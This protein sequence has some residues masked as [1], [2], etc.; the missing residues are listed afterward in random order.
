MRRLF[1][2]CLFLVGPWCWFAMQGSSAP[3]WSSP[4]PSSPPSSSPSKWPSQANAELTLTILNRTIKEG[5]QPHPNIS[6]DSD[7]VRNSSSSSIPYYYTDPLADAAPP[8]INVD[9][10]PVP[11]QVMEQYRKW[12]SVEALRSNP[13][14]E[15]RKF[16]IGFYACPIQAGNRIHHFLN[17]MLWAILTNRTL[18][19]QYWDSPTCMRWSRE[20]MV[21]RSMNREHEC[22]QILSRADWI[23]SYEEWSQTL[24]LDEP[25]EIPYHANHPKF[26]TI[27]RYTWHEGDEKLFGA[28]NRTKYAMQVAVFGISISKVSYLRSAKIRRALL[29]TDYAETTCLRL[30]RLGVNFLYGMLHRYSFVFGEQA[31]K[32]LVGYQPP[33]AKNAF[34]IALHSRHRYVE[35]D[36]CNI[37]REVQCLRE[38]TKP[39]NNRPIHVSIMADRTC[40]ITRMTKLL[41]RRNITVHVAPHDEGSSF[42]EE[43]GPF[44]GVGLY[45]DLALVSQA[46][47]AIIATL[48]TSSDLLRELVEY[49]SKMERW[50]AGGDIGK[51]KGFISCL[52]TQAAEE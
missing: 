22:D 31:R 45:Q 52:L 21:C 16:A 28:D 42:R 48:R 46:R 41:E 36:G 5:D 12:H 39:I 29:H 27:S 9:Q 13:D 35:D 3:R 7:S 24:G 23:P 40:T 32:G 37:E 50:K 49:N 30:H 15:H 10:L 1:E 33:T 6:L 47:S 17:S 2:A 44:A 43:H 51:M 38:V 14:L 4:S 19:W 8:G 11:I 18:L 20:K 26:Y 34:T 25:E